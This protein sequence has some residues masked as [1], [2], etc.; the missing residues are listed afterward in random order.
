[1]NRSDATRRSLA[2]LL[3][4][5]ADAAPPDRISLRDPILAFGAPCLAPLVELATREDKLSASVAAC[6]RPSPAAIRP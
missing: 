4:D 5:L 2:Q 3:T 6:S 1:M